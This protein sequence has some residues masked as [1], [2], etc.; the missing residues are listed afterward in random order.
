MSTIGA[1]MPFLLDL[2]PVLE[3]LFP[4]VSN[5]SSDVAPSE[6][7]ERTLRVVQNFLSCVALGDRPLIL[8]IDDL[9]WSSPAEAS[10][11]CN[12]ISSFRSTGSLGTVR[13][14]LLVLSHR[15]NEL[16][17]STLQKLKT[18][19]AKL[20]GNAPVGNDCA[21]EIQVGPLQLVSS[22]ET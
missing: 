8:F 11:L 15:A 1:D 14:C 17:E 2:V 18:S 12:L 9:Q 19:T 16:P 6:A 7:E 4:E 13:H 3:K 21:L 20:T 22:L 5:D 10:L